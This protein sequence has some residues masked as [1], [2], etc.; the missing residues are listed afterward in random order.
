VSYRP[1]EGGDILIV[2]VSSSD[3]NVTLSQLTPNTEYEI[4][5]VGILDDKS[6]TGRSDP[7]YIVIP[8]GYVCFVFVTF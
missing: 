3:L 6:K 7:A 4:T 8:D 1:K 5:V 2:F